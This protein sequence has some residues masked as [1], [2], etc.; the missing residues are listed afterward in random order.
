MQV[1][2]HYM[3]M[4]Q[5]VASKNSDSSSSSSSVAQVPIYQ[6]PAWRSVSSSTGTRDCHSREIV[7]T[8]LISFSVSYTSGFAWCFCRSI[9]VVDGL[10]PILVTKWLSSIGWCSKLYC[11]SAGARAMH[12]FGAL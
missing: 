2:R 11:T 1:L 5:Q 12:G 3:A 6:G 8:K 9:F 7:D 4:Q 10:L